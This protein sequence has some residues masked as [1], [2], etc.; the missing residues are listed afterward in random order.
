MA[1]VE[2]LAA[3][4][5][6]VA[7]RAGGISEIIEDGV[8]GVFVAPGDAVAL[9]SAVSRLLLDVRT[10][11]R[12]ECSAEVRSRTFSVEAFAARFEQ[13]ISAVLAT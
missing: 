3:R 8:S 1:I 11:E 9:A 6:V 7:S 5:A 12:I 10:R 2:A 13:L 4:R